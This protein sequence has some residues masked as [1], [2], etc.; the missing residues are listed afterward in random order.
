M[1]PHAPA[2][3]APRVGL[4]RVPLAPGVVAGDVAER[5]FGADAAPA[6]RRAPAA[7]ERGWRRR[8]VRTLLALD[9][10]AATLAACLGLGSR[11]LLSPAPL[12]SADIVLALL[13]P[14][15]WVVAVHLSRAYEDRFLG[16]G[17]EEWRRVSNAWLRLV[18]VFALVAYLAHARPSR[19]F[20]LVALPAVLAL[21]VLGRAGARARLRARQRGGLDQHRLLVVGPASS[22][23]HLA[24]QVRRGP[25]R[26]LLVVGACPT[27]GRVEVLERAAVPVLGGLDDVVAAV[28][29]TGADTVAVSAGPGLDPA[30]TRRLA[31]QLEGLGVALL[32]A[33]SIM[34]VAGPRVHVRPYAGLPLLHVEEPVLTG[35]RQV[36]KGVVDSALGLLALTLLAPLILGVAVAVKATS[37]GPVLFRQHRV[38]RHGAEFSMLKF[39]SMR[40]GAEREIDALVAHNDRSEGLLFKMRED[41]R[42]T[43]V[44]RVL[45]RY[46]LDELPQLVNVLRGEMSLVGPR[47]PLPSEV[48]RY[49]D[50]VRRRLLVRPGLTGLWQVSGRSDLPWEEAVRLDL[51]YVEN[52]SLALDAS[53]MLR[54][55]RAIVGRTGAY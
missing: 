17:S 7:A 55:L 4:H 29:R 38:G 48:A 47:P 49:G 26:A 18:G 30:M 37:R 40:D 44:G 35:G 13:L 53:I 9:A 11:T 51:H 31:W 8:L 52:W 25:D 2:R 28:E 10:C 5:G 21:S 12:P 43:R 46:S 23:L 32:L 24:E 34:D 19:A 1:T 22:V 45:R 39:R 3:P 20:V 15:G 41:P 27:S 14:V 50:D 16:T 54:T 33:P 36:A 42:V 6:P